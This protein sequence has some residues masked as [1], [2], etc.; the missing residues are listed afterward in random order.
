MSALALDQPE[1]LTVPEIGP[2]VPSFVES[3][4]PRLHTVAP[5][6]SPRKR[7]LRYAIAAIVGISVIG[8]AQVSIALMTT[9]ESFVLADRM[10][11]Q[12]ELSWEQQALEST[13]IELGSPQ[14]LA[15][16]AAGQGLVVNGS[17]HYLRLSDGALIG[18]T[19]PAA[20]WSVV[21]PQNASVANALIDTPAILPDQ[22]AWDAVFAAGVKPASATSLSVPQ[23]LKPAPVAEPEVPAPAPETVAATE[24]PAEGAPVSEA[25]AENVAPPAEQTGA[26][27]AAQHDAAQGEPVHTNE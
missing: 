19:D 16:Q 26:E 6:A 22:A 21:A 14:A 23:I 15:Q 13:V 4:R 11:T 3:K 20:P 27:V 18:S 8:V 1:L 10:Q 17:P 9:Q 24:P 25:E 5:L 2:E 7:P 12:K